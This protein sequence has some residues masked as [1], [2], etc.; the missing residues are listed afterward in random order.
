MLNGYG[1]THSHAADVETGLSFRVRSI[2]AEKRVEIALLRPCGLQNFRGKYGTE[3]EEWWLATFGY[4]FER[5]T[6]S[7]ARYLVR[8]DDA[9][10]ITTRIVAAER[11]GN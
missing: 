5:L 2:L 11:S 6:E 8:A 1:R 7:E 4:G 9:H 3:L 10:T